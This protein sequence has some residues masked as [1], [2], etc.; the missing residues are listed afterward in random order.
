MENSMSFPGKEAW[1]MTTILN[2]SATYIGD[3]ELEIA[4]DE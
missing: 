1:L 4:E 3:V 2:S